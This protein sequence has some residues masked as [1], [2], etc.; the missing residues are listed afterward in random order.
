[1]A[2]KRRRDGK[3]RPPNESEAFQRTD[4]RSSRSAS[5]PRTSHVLEIDNTGH[6]EGKDR[7]PAGPPQ[8]AS[9]FHL[10]QTFSQCRTFGGH[11]RPARRDPTPSPPLKTASSLASGTLLE[12]PNLSAGP[13]IEEQMELILIYSQRASFRAM[14]PLARG[15][16]KQCCLRHWSS[17]RNPGASMHLSR[18]S[19]RYASPPW[20]LSCA[21]GAIVGIR[22]AST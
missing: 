21:G 15:C 14:D 6:S 12:R 18:S 10:D 4:V 11:E 2:R 22:N 8:T 1:V 3:G 5:Q 7:E 19:G 17:P 16:R 20:A 9:K 13:L